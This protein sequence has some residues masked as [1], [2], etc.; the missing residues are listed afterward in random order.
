M[1]M[2]RSLFMR[3]EKDSRPRFSGAAGRVPDRRAVR[4]A[5]SPPPRFSPRAC[6]LAFRRRWSLQTTRFQKKKFSLAG[7]CSTTRGS[8]ATARTPAPAVISRRARSLTAARRR[9]APPVNP[10]REAPLPHQRRL[11]R[12]VRMGGRQAPVAGSADGGADV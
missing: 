12:H 5:A 2:G 8:P 3:L 1:I 10:M 4:R 11:Q 9:W 6:R 7:G